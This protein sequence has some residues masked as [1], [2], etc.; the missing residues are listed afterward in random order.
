M[1]SP[2]EN[3]LVVTEQANAARYSCGHCTTWNNGS[4]SDLPLEGGSGNTFGIHR[5]HS[6][7][8]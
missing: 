1:C 8:G 3:A 5:W 2:D 6:G 7:R 4:S